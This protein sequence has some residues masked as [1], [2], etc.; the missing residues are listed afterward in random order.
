VLPGDDAIVELREDTIVPGTIQEYTEPQSEF[1][2]RIEWLVKIS[3][4]VYTTISNWVL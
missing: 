3:V 2:Y 1:I 4:L